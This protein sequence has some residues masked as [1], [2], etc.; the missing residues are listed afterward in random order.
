M[1]PFFDLFKFEP[2]KVSTLHITV[3]NFKEV[4]NVLI[5]YRDF[6]INSFREWELVQ[7]NIGYSL[8]YHQK[9]FNT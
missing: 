4:L 2:D 7:P 1:I 8:S 3:H 6:L 9:A 5:H